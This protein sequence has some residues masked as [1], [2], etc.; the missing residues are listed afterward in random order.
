MGGLKPPQVL[1]VECV[2]WQPSEDIA[3]TTIYTERSEAEALIRINERR[4]DNEL[5]SSLRTMESNSI[6]SFLRQRSNRL[7]IKQNAALGKDARERSFRSGTGDSDYTGVSHAGISRHRYPGLYRTYFNDIKMKK[8]KSLLNHFYDN[9]EI[10]KNREYLDKDRDSVSH[11]DELIRQ[12]CQLL[13][14]HFLINSKQDVHFSRV[15][16]M[17]FRKTRSK[18]T[19]EFEY[20]I[21]DVLEVARLALTHNILF[22]SMAFAAVLKFH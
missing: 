4:R 10:V 17:F 15:A 22:S 16:P 19:T 11:K 5:I 12:L 14:S 8:L 18:C 2:T 1:S 13:P 20:N 7:G 3:N 6:C 9:E 21:T